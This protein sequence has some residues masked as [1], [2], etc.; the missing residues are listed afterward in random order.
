MVS[1]LR[2]VADPR[3][4]PVGM[5]AR[6]EAHSAAREGSARRPP[7]APRRP[8]WRA[9][10]ASPGPPRHRETGCMRSARARRRRAPRPCPGR[11]ATARRRPG[12]ARRPSTTGSAREGDV[13]HLGEAQHHGATRARPA[14]LDEAD[15]ARR[16]V[17]LDRQV[18]L[19][20]PT[21]LSPVAHHRCRRAET[22]RWA[23]VTRPSVAHVCARRPLRLR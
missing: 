19:A 5:Q 13:E 2:E 9:R 23:V 21:P 15:V 16:H 22:A 20:Q 8:R 3:R 4:Q 18:E 11:P 17:G 6:C 10:C 7:A 12:R 14:G 1:P